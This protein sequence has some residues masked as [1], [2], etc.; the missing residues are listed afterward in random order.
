M[1]TILVLD[2][3]LGDRALKENQVTRGSRSNSAKM[4][5]VSEAIG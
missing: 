1:D 3:G 5:M 4:L 2:F